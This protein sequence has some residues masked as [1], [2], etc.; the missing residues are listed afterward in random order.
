MPAGARW[1]FPMKLRHLVFC[2]FACVPALL[3]EDVEFSDSFARP[4]GMVR[5][6]NLNL[7]A[8]QS[9]AVVFADGPVSWTTRSLGTLPRMEFLLSDRRLVAVLGGPSSLY[10]RVYAAPERDFG[11]GLAGKHYRVALEVSL[12]LFAPD[13][14]TGTGLNLT[15]VRVLLGSSLEDLVGS[16]AGKWNVAVR[17]TPFYHA[18]SSAWKMRPVV[19]V[20]GAQVAGVPD[21][22]FV[23]EG[24]GEK[25][26][27]PALRLV[28]DVDE[29]RGQ[30]T[31]LLGDEK[32]VEDHAL[33]GAFPDGVRKLVLGAVRS[34]GMPDVQ[35]EFG[36]VQIVVMP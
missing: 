34:G 11:P 31:V 28:L 7:A 33:A 19:T 12:E 9:G 18:A 26:R 14:I 16:E 27:T 15:D 6:I 21:V 25:N 30:V 13:A 20:A 32:L 3:A 23:P 17:L 10:G 24:S 4:G 36:G 1:F 5:D 22:V 8:R 2:V 29:A 35:H